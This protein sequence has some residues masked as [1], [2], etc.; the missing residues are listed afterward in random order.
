LL[1][2]A[3]GLAGLA[4][5][6]KYFGVCLIPLLAAFSLLERASWRRWVGPLVLAAAMAAD[7]ELFTRIRYGQGLFSSAMLYSANVQGLVKDPSVHVR[8]AQ[9]VGRR[10]V[11]LL[12]FLGG[13]SGTSLFLLPWLWGPRGLGLI[14]VLTGLALFAGPPAV[15]FV[16]CP[17][18]SYWLLAIQMTLAVGAALAA[19]G[20]AVTDLWRRRDT[21]SCLLFL[22]MAGTALFAGFLNWTIA[23]RSLLPLVPAL[24]ILLARRLDERYGHGTALPHQAQWQSFDEQPEGQQF[25]GTLKRPVWNRL[26][27][28]P[29]CCALVCAAILSLLVTIAD[30]AQAESVRQ[31]AVALARDFVGRDGTCWFEGHWGFQYYFQLQ[32]ARCW[33]RN[34][35]QAWPGDWLIFP[36][37]NTN[38]DPLPRD[39]FTLIDMRRE[40][41]CRWLATMKLGSGAGFYSSQ[42]GPLP[43]VFGPIPPET[44]VILRFVKPLDSAAGGSE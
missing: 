4:A 1:Y 15:L 2:V 28:L 22:W 44:Y 43:Y 8:T 38:L 39:R 18:E 21:V 23:A 14:A 12:S 9:R 27:L 35:S 13:C 19:A 32:G 5:L 3:A 34:A 11:V 31:S 36:L 6:T 41:A 26:P 42:F 40:A 24:G 25:S 33:D 10:L 17:P 29:A 20:L 37:N 16:E 7:Y 30:A